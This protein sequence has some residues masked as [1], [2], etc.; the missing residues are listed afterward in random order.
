MSRCFDG[1]FIYHG[2]NI[3]QIKPRGNG[4]QRHFAN[5]WHYEFRRCKKW[6]FADTDCPK[7]LYSAFHIF[8]NMLLF[9]TFYFFFIYIS[10]RSSICLIACLSVNVWCGQ[11]IIL[12]EQICGQRDNYRKTFLLNIN[13]L[14][15]F[16]HT[17]VHCIWRRFG[18]NVRHEEA[19]KDIKVQCKYEEKC[20]EQK[21]LERRDKI[22]SWKKLGRSACRERIVVYAFWVKI[23]FFFFCI[24]IWRTVT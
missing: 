19:C 11:Y 4:F 24:L 2:P 16:G 7:A 21:M 18:H 23:F 10:G 3:C 20:R 22:T 13:S 1:G 8:E 12:E 6:F 17:A 9:V 14:S 5:L 15:L